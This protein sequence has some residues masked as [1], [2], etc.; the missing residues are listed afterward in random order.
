VLL[1][2]CNDQFKPS[3]DLNRKTGQ[4]EKRGRSMNTLL[5]LAPA[6]LLAIFAGHALADSAAGTWKTIDDKSGQAKALVQISESGSGELTGKI[7]KL[8]IHPDAV[9]DKCDGEKKD[10]PIVGMTILWGLK[11][12]GDMW[13]DGKILDPKEGK[14]YSSKAKLADGGSKLEVR[15]FIGVSLLGRTQTWVRQ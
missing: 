5:K 14:V 7:V 13:V 3:F 11:K 6:A 8:F 2:V 4:H 15:G 9:C 10:K 1:A 12:D